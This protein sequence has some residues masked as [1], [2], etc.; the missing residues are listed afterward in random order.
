VE[1]NGGVA[2][3][4]TFFSEDIADEI[5]IKGRTARQGQTGSFQIITF[6]EQLCTFNY[7]VPQIQTF[8]S[9]N[10]YTKMCEQRIRVFYNHIQLI[11]KLQGLKVVHEASSNLMNLLC[12]AESSKI[13]S[14]IELFYMICVPAP[15]TKPFHFYPVLD[16]SGSMTYDVRSTI[17]NETRWDVLVRIIIDFFN[18]RKSCNSDDIYTII[19]HDDNVYVDHE[20]PRPI[21]EDPSPLFILHKGDNDFGLALQQTKFEIDK[22]KHYKYIPFL[23]F[24]SDGIDFNNGGEPEMNEIYLAHFQHGLIVKIIGFS[25]GSGD[26]KLEALARCGRGEFLNS[27]DGVQL[28]QTF[29]DIAFKLEEGFSK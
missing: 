23:L 13:E 5:Q 22:N 27:L 20:A 3:I 12:M 6:E 10:L 11:E 2:V 4:S 29:D 17:A 28:E 24:L 16:C 15:Q 7:T 9:Q 8:S 18:R 21:Q 1:K 25:C 14:A 19:L 26:N